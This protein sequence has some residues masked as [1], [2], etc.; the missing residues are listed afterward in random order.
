M[1][2][3]SDVF[4]VVLTGIYNTESCLSRALSVFAAVAVDPGLKATLMAHRQKAEAH[5]KKLQTVFADFGWPTD[6]KEAVKESPRRELRLNVDAEAVQNI[7]D[8]LIYAI[9]RIGRYKI[10]SYECLREW[11]IRL[12]HPGAA[13]RMDE[14]LEEE[15]ASDRALTTLAYRPVSIR[16]CAE[17]QET[18]MAA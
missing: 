18:S 15:A 7:D 4:V 17:T 6:A 2:T 8:G 11:A 16:A 12:D 10:A 13:A 5:A 9:Q 14:I 3:L 1:K